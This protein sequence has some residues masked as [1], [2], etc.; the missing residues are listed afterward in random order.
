M[1]FVKRNDS[2]LLE[3]LLD[4]NWTIFREYEYKQGATTVL[5]NAYETLEN[6]RG[7]C[8]DFAIL[9]IA[10]AR[11]LGIPARYVCGYLYTGPRNTNQVQSEASHAWVQLYLPELGWT[12]FD[13]TNG[14]ITQTAHVRVAVGRS[15]I[16]ATPTGGTIYLGGGKETLEASVSVELIEPDRP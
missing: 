3:T 5:T 14:C 13:P 15:Y 8:Q 9:F 11:L 12:G 16:D 2:D 10:L 7:V 1:S 6:R 4:I